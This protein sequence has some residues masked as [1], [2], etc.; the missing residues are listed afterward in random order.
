MIRDDIGNLNVGLGEVRC[1]TVF[2]YDHCFVVIELI[3]ACKVDYGM[4]KRIRLQLI[5]DIV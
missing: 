1:P 2:G 4:I 3:Y 5:Q